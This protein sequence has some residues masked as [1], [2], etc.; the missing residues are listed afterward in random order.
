MKRKVAPCKHI[1]CPSQVYARGLCKS[2]LRRVTGELTGPVKH[3]ARNKGHLCRLVCDRPAH[4]GGLCKR[5][6]RRKCEGLDNWHAPLLSRA[7]NGSLPLGRVRV[8]EKYAEFYR[9]LAEGL[10]MTLN[11]LAT[12]LLEEYAQSRLN[13]QVDD[14]GELT[15]E[16]WRRKA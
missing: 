9:L 14:E 7:T 5:H 3:Y 15:T 2:H 11:A 16:K 8:R 13:E 6:Y 10:G 4:V 12:Y 1:G